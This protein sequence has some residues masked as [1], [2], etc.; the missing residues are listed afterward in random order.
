[1]VQQRHRARPSAYRHL[2]AGLCALRGAVP[3][4]RSD[5]SRW[6]SRRRGRPRW[7]RGYPRHRP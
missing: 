4:A 7:P 5:K 6:P 1:M 3:S 2:L